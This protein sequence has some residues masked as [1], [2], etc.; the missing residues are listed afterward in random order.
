M[1]VL[2]VGVDVEMDV[3]SLWKWNLLTNTQD[4]VFDS[5]SNNKVIA[6]KSMFFM[7]CNCGCLHSYDGFTCGKLTFTSAW[8]M[9]FNTL[10]QI[11]AC[12]H[13][14]LTLINR[15]IREHEF[16]KLKP[17]AAYI[18]VTKPL[19]EFI[20]H[21]K[22]QWS[23]FDSIQFVCRITMGDIAYVTKQIIVVILFPEEYNIIHSIHIIFQ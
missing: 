19:L 17:Y 12:I 15:K 23:K 4:Q 6:Y 21:V 14:F 2:F 10:E 8:N 13:R 5:V 22:C 1:S 7:N 16:L 20:L 18:Q 9:C 11:V 3:S